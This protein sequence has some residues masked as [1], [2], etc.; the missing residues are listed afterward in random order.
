[1]YTSVRDTAPA[2]RKFIAY[3]SSR[4]PENEFFTRSKILRLQYV[5]L[6][7]TAYE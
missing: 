6:K 4:T 1:M 3:E 2:V 7:K 5:S